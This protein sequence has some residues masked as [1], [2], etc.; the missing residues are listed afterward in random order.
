MRGVCNMLAFIGIGPGDPELL[1]LKAA[2]LLREADAIALP[3][4]GVAMQ[5]VRE[6][7]QEKPVLTLDL[8]MRGTRAEWMRAH[9]QAA[10]AL[11]AYLKDYS[12]VAFPVLGDPGIYAT[13]SYLYRRIR[14]LHP[15]EIVPGIPAMCAAAAKLGVPLCEKG[16]SLTVLDHF[17]GKAELPPGNTVVMKSGKR[18]EELRGAA[19]GREAYVVRN[20]GMDGEWC[21]ALADAP[22]M[23]AFYFTTTIVRPSGNGD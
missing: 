20:L 14:A 9:E 11:L 12:S 23:D 4:R 22:E 21:G 7:I 10:E 18:M 1:T 15:C 2:R 13:S 5:I 3:D 17:D 6:W 19:R 8:P 16:E